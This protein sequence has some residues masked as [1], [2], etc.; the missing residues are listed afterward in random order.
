MLGP[1]YFNPPV[2]GSNMAP[3]KALPEPAYVYSDEFQRFDYGPQHPMRMRRLALTN[4]LIGLCGLAAEA[5]PLRSG[6]LRR[7]DDLS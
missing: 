7:A 5:T 3:N 1:L 4:E 6:Q 2:A